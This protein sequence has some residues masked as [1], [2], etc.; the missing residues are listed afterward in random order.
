MYVCPQ[1][2]WLSFTPLKDMLV[3]AQRQRAKVTGERP[4]D[5]MLPLQL[6][7]N[8]GRVLLQEE[9]SMDIID[10]LDRAAQGKLIKKDTEI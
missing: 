2:F 4:D 3:E 6:S 10:T 9:F 8:R 5:V 1:Q 7:F